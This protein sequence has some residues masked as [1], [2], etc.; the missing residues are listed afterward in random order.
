MNGD[1]RCL[2]G[3][4]LDPFSLGGCVGHRGSTGPLDAEKRLIGFL[5]SGGQER[6]RYQRGSTDSLAAVDSNVPPRREGFLQDPH[7][8]GR[9]HSRLGHAA[10]RNREGMKLQPLLAGKSL[11]FPKLQ[12]RHLL[13]RQ[14]RCHN[15]EARLSPHPHFIREPVTASWAGKDGKATGPGAWHPVDFRLHSFFLSFSVPPHDNLSWELV[16]IDAAVSKNVDAMVS[17]HDRPIWSR[18]QCAGLARAQR[19]D[20]VLGG[21]LPESCQLRPAQRFIIM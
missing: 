5:T 14:Q 12:L 8:F 16:D 4:L 10:V 13:L 9:L 21:Q 11:L 2:K 7:Q 20:Q 6:R 17:L 18:F 3:S 15:L 19:S 1:H